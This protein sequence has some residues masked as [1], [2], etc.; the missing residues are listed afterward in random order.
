MERILLHP[1][2]KTVASQKR[3]RSDNHQTEKLYFTL[4]NYKSLSKFTA[5]TKMTVAQKMTRSVK[6]FT[7]NV[8]FLERK[9]QEASGILL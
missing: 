3:L 4:L 8:T 9:Q 6:S 2:A 7:A 5:T 1:G